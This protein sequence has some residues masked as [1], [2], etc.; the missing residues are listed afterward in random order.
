VAALPVLVFLFFVRPKS[1]QVT[2]PVTPTMIALLGRRD[3][4]TD[5]LED[6]CRLLREAL[7]REGQE[8][9]LVWTPWPEMGW[10][11]AFLW[12]WR[13]SRGWQDRWILVQYTALSWSRRGIPLN[14]LVVLGMVKVRRARV[15]VVFHDPGTYRADRVMERIR[16]CLQW[17]V[18]RAAH[19]L[20]E[21]SVLTVPLTGVRWLPGGSRKAFFIPIGANVPAIQKQQ[22]NGASHA[23]RPKTVAVFGITGGGAIPREIDDI[24]YAMSHVAR[25]FENPRLLTLGRGSEEAEGKLRRALDG[26]SVDLVAMG[27]LP[28]E[29]ISSL[30][31]SSDALLF[32][33]GPISTNRGSA[34]AGIACG[35]PVVGYSGSDAQSPLAEAGVV[36]VPQDNR[37]ALAREL[38]RVLSNE[39][40]WETLHQ[41]NLLAWQ[42]HFSWSSIARQFMKALENGAAV[43]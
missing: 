31:T 2:L 34:I 26:A 39:Q 6:Y 13:H 15:A 22:S 37:E 12:L 17:C 29:E 1:W 30:L 42:R 35:L 10:I 5:A 24:A 23:A 7:A 20:A 41:R 21:K 25:H 3:S 14:L 40:L 4:P 16:A 38:T 11:R 8:L 19:R 33:R 43:E 28:P 27:V 32:V 18:L 36:L 9:S